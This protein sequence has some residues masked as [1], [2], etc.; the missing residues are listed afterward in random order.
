MM[1][2]IVQI[3]DAEKEYVGGGGGWGKISSKKTL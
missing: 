1:I 2:N 3:E